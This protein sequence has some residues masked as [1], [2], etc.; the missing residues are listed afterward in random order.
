MWVQDAVLTPLNNVTSDVLVKQGTG[1]YGQKRQYA[2]VGISGPTQSGNQKSSA[3]SRQVPLV[4]GLVFLPLPYLLDDWNW[5]DVVN[6]S[7]MM[8]AITLWYW[9]SIRWVDKHSSWDQ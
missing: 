7:G 3:L 1:D 4:F 8:F 5:M 9:L 2:P 6:W